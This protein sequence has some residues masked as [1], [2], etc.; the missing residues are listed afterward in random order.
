[1]RTVI[2]FVLAIILAGCTAQNN[3]TS[4]AGAKLE[5]DSKSAAHEAGEKAYK[6][7]Q[8]TKKAAKV[9]GEKIREATAEAHQGWD[10]AKQKAESNRSR[11]DEDTR[12]RRR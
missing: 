3:R 10:E 2:P 6:L 5:R 12:S 1:M 8:E 9:A 7:T 4:D 11:Q